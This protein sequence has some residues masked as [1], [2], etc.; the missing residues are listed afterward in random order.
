[1]G[2]WNSVPVQAPQALTMRGLRRA[3]YESLRSQWQ[4]NDL[5]T[6]PPSATLLMM[7]TFVAGMPAPD[8]VR[9][10]RRGQLVP[11][12]GQRAD[13]GRERLP[14]LI[15]SRPRLRQSGHHRQQRGAD[16]RRQRRGRS[17]ARGRIRRTELGEE[18][19]DRSVDQR[20]RTSF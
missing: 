15:R 13:G 14:I 2:A 12:L 6:F 7:V 5:V 17:A 20:H 16:R 4:L 11:G 3:Y 18:I 9:I 1:M 19:A 8:R 10:D